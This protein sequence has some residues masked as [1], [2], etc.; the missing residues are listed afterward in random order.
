MKKERIFRCPVTALMLMALLL[1]GCAHGVD[2]ADAVVRVENNA[3]EELFD[4]GF[5]TSTGKLPIEDNSSL[6]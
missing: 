2:T 4:N 5:M 3:A 1:S 6:Y